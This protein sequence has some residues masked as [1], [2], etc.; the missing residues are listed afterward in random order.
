VVRAREESF[1]YAL[2]VRPTQAILD[3][4]NHYLQVLDIHKP[5]ELWRE[6]LRAAEHAIDR[7]RAARGLAHAGRATAVPALVAALA[8]DA[9]WAVRGAAALALGELGTEEACRAIARALE[10]EQHP[11]ARRQIVRA[12]GSLRHDAVAAAAVIRALEHD[13]SY[14]V[15]AE[16]ALALARLRAPHA[17]ELLCAAARRPSHLDVIAATCLTGLGELRDERGVAVA[18]AAAAP[19]QPAASRCAAVRVLGVRGADHATHR[20]R[21]REALAEQLDDP[22]LRLRIAAVEALQRLGDGEVI[23]VLRRAEQREREPRVRRRLREAVDRLSRQAEPSEALRQLRDAMETLELANRELR[24]RLARL[25]A[26]LE[27]A[28]SAPTVRES[29]E[30][31]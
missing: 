20:S 18:L 12:L 4:G 26:Q 8:G 29:G 30:L 16:A 25:E 7:L 19:D 22:D 9:F 21:V 15:S 24:D 5:D 11:K 31:R 2:E 28:G 6:E 14:L 10:V 27:R 23:Q 17:F 1:V 13:A 3:P